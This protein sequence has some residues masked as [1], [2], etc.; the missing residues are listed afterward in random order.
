MSDVELLQTSLPCTGEAEKLAIG[1]VLDSGYL[2][3]GPEVAAFEQEIAN[4]LGNKD[5]VACV[6]TGTS[7]LHLACEALGLGPGDE[8]L[9]PS[10]T[11]V[12]CFQAIAASGARPVACD[13]RLQ[14][15]LLD[16][17][18]ASRHL[19]EITRAIMPVFYAGY[20]G[21]LAAVYAF[22][23]QHG[24]RVIEDAAHAFGSRTSETLVGSQGDITCF[25][26]DPIKNI[27]A[28]EGGAVVSRNPDIIERVRE[29]RQLGI[30][31]SGQDDFDVSSR[32]WRFQMPD[33]MAAIGRT[34]LARFESELKPARQALHCLYRK[35]LE[36]IPGVS[37]L[38]TSTDVVP[39]IMPIRL[40][41][42]KRD[43][44][45]KTLLAAGFDTRVHYK[46][47]HLLERFNNGYRC[48]V[49]EQLFSELL[50]LP[51]H[52]GV[53]ET[54]VKQITGIIVAGVRGA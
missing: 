54:Q 27:T 15:G 49:S 29:M 36:H 46:P 41:A 2:G 50:T 23:S 19:T 28:G 22:A 35:N 12:A 40:P 9:V 20:P 11:Y 17:D 13:V 21:D 37:L 6:N 24:L 48:P 34:Q 32:G 38:E 39:H 1:R 31:K 7:A 14:D 3:M 45:R 10:L 44:I 47:N 33:L 26:F 52:P 43:S 42:T 16:L 51:T 18:D 8:V 25:S 5:S 30:R 53:S 4:Y